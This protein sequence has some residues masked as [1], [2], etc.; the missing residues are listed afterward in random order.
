MIECFQ[1]AVFLITVE[2]NSLRREI[3]VEQ[4]FSWTYPLVFSL[5]T[6]NIYPES[7]KAAFSH[8]IGNAEIELP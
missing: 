7:H 6:D 5:P 2:Y 4:M 1:N 8:N 3:F